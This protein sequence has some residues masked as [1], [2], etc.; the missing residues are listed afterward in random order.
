[1]KNKELILKKINE[2]AKEQNIRILYACESGSRAWGF[3]SPDSD[4]DVRFIY[5]RNVK[6]YLS[7]NNIKDTLEFPIE[8]ELDFVGWD[9]KKFLLL[10][11]K[12]NSNILEWL[13]SPIVYLDEDQFKTS[14]QKIIP[15]YFSTKKTI[16]YYL[17]TAK[18]KLLIIENSQEAKLKDYFYLLRTT[19]AAGWVFQYKS[20]PPMEFY[21]LFEQAKKHLDDSH[22][23]LILQ[24]LQLKEKSNET[25][26]IPKIPNLNQF[27]KSK[28]NYYQNLLGDMEDKIG[29][30]NKLNDIF[31][32]SV[33]YERN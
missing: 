4:Y 9:L 29:D 6:D 23:Q 19:F 17:G 10:L 18:Q 32:K 25:E 24:L 12:S 3:A 11:L 31:L 27:I 13:Q 21:P 14:Y 1:M 5:V 16:G 15:E 33:L 8:D 28:I 2:I 7:L 22:Y 20:V 26:L 30:I